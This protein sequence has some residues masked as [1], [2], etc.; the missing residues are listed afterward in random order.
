MFQLLSDFR[1]VCCYSI[2]QL[3]WLL[4][5][6]I[7]YRLGATTSDNQKIFESLNFSL[8]AFVQN[9]SNSFIIELFALMTLHL[10]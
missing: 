5:V 4:I 1:F 3:V 2:A 9:N 6:L 10:L 7:T 8:F